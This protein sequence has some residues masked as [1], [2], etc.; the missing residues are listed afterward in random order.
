MNVF[1]HC[2]F[3]IREYFHQSRF[4]FMFYVHLHIKPFIVSFIQVNYY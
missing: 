1:S 2:L 3:F 4:K